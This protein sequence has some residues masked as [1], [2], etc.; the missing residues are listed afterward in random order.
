MKILKQLSKILF[1]LYL[2]LFVQNSHAEEIKN[3][4]S[5]IEKKEVSNNKLNNVD[6]SNNKNQTQG[7][8]VQLSNENILVDQNL[9][10]SNV[11]LA[12]LFDPDLNDLNL[13]MWTNTN[14]LE[15]KKLLEKIQTKKKMQKLKIYLIVLKFS[16]GKIFSICLS[17]AGKL[18]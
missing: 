16:F 4:W 2:F 5:E 8:K 12:G 7:I 6:I 11:L 13:E 10:N 3:I 9:D 14:G 1:S 15:I 17:G 18:I